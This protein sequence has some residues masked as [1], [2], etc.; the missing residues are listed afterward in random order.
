MVNLF[1]GHA[2]YELKGAVWD[3]SATEIP[4]DAVLDAI[5]RSWL[6]QHIIAIQVLL[7]R[8]ERIVEPAAGATS[9]TASCGDQVFTRPAAHY[10]DYRTPI[11]GLY[12]RLPAPWRQGSRI[13]VQRRARSQGPRKR[14]D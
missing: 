14:L 6:A 12:S 5:L 1:G 11:R 10:A 2:P 3:E 4:V 8:P 13:P 9:S 7:A